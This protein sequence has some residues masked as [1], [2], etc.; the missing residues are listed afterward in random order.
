MVNEIGR[1]AWVTAREARGR[2]D[3][4]PLALAAL[5]RARAAV[6]VVDW[7]DRSVDWAAYDRV[8]LRSTWDYPQRL[9]EFLTWLDEVTQVTELVNPPQLVRWSLD[10]R[11]LAELEAAGVPITPT[12]FVEPGST[13]EFPDGD[14]V[15]KPSVGAGSRDAASYGTED[16]AAA[17]A[18][19]ARLHADGQVV[20]VQPFLKSVPVDGEWPMVFFD[21]RFSHAASKR[22]DLPRAGAVDDLFAVET[23]AAH[24]AAQDQIE[25]AQAAV[26]LVTSRFGTPTYARIDLVRDND[27]RYCVL[28]VELVEPSLFLP[29]ADPAAADRLAAV[30]TSP[31]DGR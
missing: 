12:V 7:D 22:V 19:V 2:D 25:V 1:L 4:E 8:V 30:L 24:T 16:H 20:L 21:G 29:Q 9:A 10:K 18:H 28:E 3:D 6:D 15:V 5:G 13:A 31:R 23:N 26:D 11:Y 17:A 14:F 27:G